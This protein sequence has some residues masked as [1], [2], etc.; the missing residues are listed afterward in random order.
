MAEH[1]LW[2]LHLNAPL[3]ISLSLGFFFLYDKG[4]VLSVWNNAPAT[5]TLVVLMYIFVKYYGILDSDFCF[6]MALMSG[7]AL[8]APYCCSLAGWAHPDK[9]DGMFNLKGIVNGSP[10]KKA[11]QTFISIGSPVTFHTAFFCMYGWTSAKACRFADQCS[12]LT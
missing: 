4:W 10:Y 6:L 7:R 8:P 1:K 5:H 2:A 3:N 9:Q 11:I 12:C